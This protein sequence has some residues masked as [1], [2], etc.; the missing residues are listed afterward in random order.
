MKGITYEDLVK[1]YGLEVCP[2]EPGCVYSPS[3]HKR[4]KISHWRGDVMHWY[5]NRS[6]TRP[7][8]LA[9]LRA[10]ARDRT[11]LAIASGSTKYDKWFKRI[12]EECMW[13]QRE[14]QETWKLKI[15]RSAFRREKGWIM[16][17]WYKPMIAKG[18]MNIEEY[19]TPMYMWAS[20]QEEEK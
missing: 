19:T 14:A 15:P 10:L 4:G 17:Y 12:G 1:H 5:M 8:L 18:E 6:V 3:T 7:G 9:F 20:T 2:G 11:E 16:S 13:A